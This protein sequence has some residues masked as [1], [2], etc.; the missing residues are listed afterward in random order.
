M[1]WFDAFKVIATVVVLPMIYWIGRLQQQHND[2]RLYVAENYVS[3]DDHKRDL[4]NLREY[5]KEGFQSIL[6][7]LDRFEKEIRKELDRKEDKK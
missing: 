1:E 6:E 2:F 4:E 7:R 3:K 5:I